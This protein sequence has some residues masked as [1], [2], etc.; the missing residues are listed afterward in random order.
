MARKSMAAHSTSTKPSPAKI[1]VVVAAVVAASVA[2]VAA[3]AVIAVAA[4]AA[5]A[6]EITAAVVAVV[7]AS[8][9]GKY[10]LHERRSRIHRER[11]SSHFTCSFPAPADVGNTTHQQ[12]TI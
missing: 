3:S 10:S 2:V 1:A 7:T 6:V 4:A 12:S 8:L 9:V 11:A 5:V